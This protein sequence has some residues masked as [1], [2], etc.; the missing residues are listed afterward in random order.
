MATREEVELRL[1]TIIYD[2]AEDMKK[3]MEGLLEPTEREVRLGS[4]EVREIFRISRLGT[5]AGC[6]VADGK[7]TRSAQVRLLRDNVVD[8]HREG[9]LAQAIQGRRQRGEGRPRVRYRNRRVQ[10]HQAG[11]RHRVLYH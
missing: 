10:R 9:R 6:L 3:A 11:G 8:P 1:Y 4:A 5:I 7:V 2:V